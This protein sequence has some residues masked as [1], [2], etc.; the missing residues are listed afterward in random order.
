MAT[1]AT[2]DCVG[3]V[4]VPVVHATLVQLPLLAV[5]AYHRLLRVS[6]PRALP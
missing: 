4:D 1:V 6:T 5:D 2:V 3:P